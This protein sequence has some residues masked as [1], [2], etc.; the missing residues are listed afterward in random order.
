M[1]PNDPL[2]ITYVVPDG[3]EAIGV[4]EAE[5]GVPVALADDPYVISDGTSLEAPIPVF[6]A[7]EP[8]W[9]NSAGQ[10]LPAL[11]VTGLEPPMDYPWVLESGNWEVS[12]YWLIGRP[13]EETTLNA[14]TVD[15]ITVT[16]NGETVTNA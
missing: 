2:G 12:K 8:T 11:A 15:G 6:D 7:G 10:L 5:G 13:W 9:L 1:G 14:V 3:Q 16:H 4:Y